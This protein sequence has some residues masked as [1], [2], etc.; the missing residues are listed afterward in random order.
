[1]LSR[2]VNPWSALFSASRSPRGIRARL[3][4]SRT[5]PRHSI[6]QVFA[7]SASTLSGFSMRLISCAPGALF[8]SFIVLPSF[9]FTLGTAV[10]P[11]GQNGNEARAFRS[12][13]RQAGMGCQSTAMTVGNKKNHEPAILSPAHGLCHTIKAVRAIRRATPPL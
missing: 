5:R 2:C 10:F 7:L 1:L 9:F 13:P 11:C 3:L 8:V 4:A 12:W 6:V